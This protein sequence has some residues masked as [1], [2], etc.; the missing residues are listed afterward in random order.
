MLRDAPVFSV[1]WAGGERLRF[2]AAFA[3]WLVRWEEDFALQAILGIS[4]AGRAGMRL[5]S[6]AGW[7]PVEARFVVD[8]RPPKHLAA[9]FTKFLGAAAVGQESGEQGA[10]FQ[11]VLDREWSDGG[12]EWWSRG[13][14]DEWISGL[15][16]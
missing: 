13:R 2:G 7:A 4:L 16:D 3:G 14:R 8:T 1:Q 10:A 11:T 15:L 5:S 9:V 6:I 12:V